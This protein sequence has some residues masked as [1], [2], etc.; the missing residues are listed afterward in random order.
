MYVCERE[1]EGGR[2]RGRV[3]C[4]RVRKSIRGE[5][6]VQREVVWEKDW[7]RKVHKGENVTS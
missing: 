5:R 3:R 2:S 1:R 4:G 7:G 6:E